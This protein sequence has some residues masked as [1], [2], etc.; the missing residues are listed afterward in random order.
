MAR[1]EHVERHVLELDAEIFRDRLAAG[2]DGDVLQHGLAAIAEARRLDGG[3]LEAAAQLVDDE[4][5]ERLALDLFGDDQQ[6]TARLHHR[7]EHRQ[8]LL[9]VRQLL[10]VDEDVGVLELGHHLLG[11]GDEVGREIA[12]VELHA[13]DD[14]Q[15][16]VEALGLLDRDDALVADLLHGFGDHVADGLLAVGRDGADLGDLARVLDLLGALGDLLDDLGNR[17]VDAAAQ[18]HRVHA[19]GN[20]LEAFAHDGLGEDRGGRRAVTGEIVGLLGNLAHHLRAHVLELVL[21]LDLL[22]DGDAVLGR[23]RRAE[24]L[25]DDDVAA[26]GTE[27]HLHGVGEGI[28]AAQQALAG[29]GGEADFFGSH[30]GN[31]LDVA[32]A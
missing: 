20:G 15:L 18:I 11:V 16:G 21:E 12:A 22:G 26:L 13:L 17:L 28:D 4:R 3:D 1:P 7:F 30:S 24:R 8:Q 25:L 31:S 2:E 27:R 32:C 23:A 29:I 9:Q 5:G 19:G 14:F 6:R 10:L